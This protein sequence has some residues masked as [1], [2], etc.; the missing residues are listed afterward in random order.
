MNPNQIAKAYQDNAILTASPGKLIEMLLKGM[1]KF[2]QEADHGFSESNV[3]Q[4][5]TLVHN[6]ISKAQ[7]IVVELQAS[8]QMEPKTEFAVTMYR[9][10][11][12][13][14]QKLQDANM[15]KNRL[16]LQEVMPIAEEISTAWS[17]MLSKATQPTNN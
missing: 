13:M 12:F 6:N 14:S 7:S 15:Q 11:D 16:I 8:L 9:L 2:L 10:Y 3:I 5:N 1:M 4:R 17:E